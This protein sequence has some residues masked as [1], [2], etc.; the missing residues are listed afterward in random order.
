MLLVYLLIIAVV[1]LLAFSL[2]RETGKNTKYARRQG[3]TLV[4]NRVGTSQQIS[5][6]NPSEAS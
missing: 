1:V 6:S 4:E 5:M 3:N 2:S